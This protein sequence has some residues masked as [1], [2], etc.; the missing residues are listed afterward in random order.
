MPAHYRTLYTACYDFAFQD[1]DFSQTVPPATGSTHPQHNVA[2][3][4]FDPL[5]PSSGGGGLLANMEICQDS[6]PAPQ[7]NI[8]G[9]PTANN[10]QR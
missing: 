7:E 9:P 8:S 10:D 3:M 5:A 1:I 2:E 4:N 6:L